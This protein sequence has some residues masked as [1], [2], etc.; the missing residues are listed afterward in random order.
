M[1]FRYPIA[2]NMNF[3]PQPLSFILMKDIE[4]AGFLDAGVVSNQLQNLPDS[5]LLSSAGAGIRFYNFAFQRALV[6]LRFDV[7]WRLDQAGPPSF[8]FNLTPM[9]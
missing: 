6:M 8:H 9:F 3:I 5:P 2:T 7:A 1:K 4:L